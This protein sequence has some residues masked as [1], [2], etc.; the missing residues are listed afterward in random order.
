MQP[1][2]APSTHSAS[3]PAPSTLAPSVPLSSIP[4]LGVRQILEETRQKVRQTCSIYLAEPCADICD[5]AAHLEQIHLANSLMNRAH[6]RLRILEQLVAC[7]NGSD[8]PRF[9]MDCGELIPFQRIA[10]N[11]EALRCMACQE[12]WEDSRTDG[13]HFSRNIQHKGSG[14]AGNCT[15]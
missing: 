8:G 2:R 1:A 11:P 15:K 13:I 14:Y 7:P 12:D 3:A 6:E 10:A 5:D 4:L 9:C